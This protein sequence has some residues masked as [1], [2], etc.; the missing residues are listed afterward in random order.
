MILNE[1]IKKYCVQNIG[2]PYSDMIILRKNFIDAVTSFSELGYRIIEVSWWMHKE[3]DECIDD[4]SMGGPVDKNSS[5]FFWAET[6][7]EG[8]KFETEELNKNLKE[9]V[10]YYYDFIKNDKNVL[11]PAITLDLAFKK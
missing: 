10:S 8:K 7:M 5:R 3:V 9:V 6:I 11:Y 2:I 1:V 4:I